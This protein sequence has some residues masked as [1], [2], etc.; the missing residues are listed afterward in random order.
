MHIILKCM[1]RVLWTWSRT[2]ERI[3][4]QHTLHR[5]IADTWMFLEVF[6][7]LEFILEGT[8]KVSNVFGRCGL[9]TVKKDEIIKMLPVPE[10]KKTYRRTV[11]MHRMT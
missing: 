1:R 5:Q 4:F 11:L 2:L 9:S 8:R 6:S 7:A 10:P 3:S